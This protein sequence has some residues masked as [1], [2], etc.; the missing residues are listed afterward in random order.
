MR[1]TELNSRVG[2]E[3]ARTLGLDERAPVHAEPILNYGGFVNRSFR[4]STPAGLRHVKLTDAN[5]SRRRLERSH[6]VAERLAADYLA[7]APRG[8]LRIPGTGF[9]GPVSEW[10]EGRRPAPPLVGRLRQQLV[11]VVSRLHTDGDLAAELERLGSTTRSC[12]EAYRGSYHERFVDDLAYVRK[13]PPPFVAADLLGWLAVEVAYLARRVD[14]SPAFDRP[15]A[16]PTHGDLWIDNLLA[17]YAGDA[18]GADAGLDD[19]GTTDP[20][21]LFILDWDEVGL[22]DPA[23]DWAMLFG[24]SR[25]LVEPL[26]P[27]ALADMPLTDGE[28]DRLLLFRRASLLDWIIDPLADWVAA[29]AEPVHGATVRSA[30]RSVHERALDRYRSLWR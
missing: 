26:D 8:W 27:E 17:G 20:A 14:D 5:H 23:M 28:R 2:R 22:G 30:N 6:A 11:D 13:N 4:V 12:A 25:E 29:A 15:A 9:A 21:E 1:L 19:G 24:P 10:I 18:A 16:R 3:L 7:P